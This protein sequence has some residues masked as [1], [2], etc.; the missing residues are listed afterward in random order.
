[1]TSSAGSTRSRPSTRREDQDRRRRVH[2]RGGCSA[3]TRRPRRSGA[4]SG[5]RSCRR[6]C[7]AQAQRPR[8][9]GPGRACQRRRRRRGHRPPSDRVRPVGR[10]GE[11]RRSDGVVGR[12]RADPL[13]AS[14]RELLGS[15]GF[16]ERQVDIKAWERRGPTS[17]PIRTDAPLGTNRA[18]GMP[19]QRRVVDRFAGVCDAGNGVNPPTRAAVA[20]ASHRWVRA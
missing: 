5:G 18:V 8:P 20:S 11:H 17:L 14:T 4:R 3:A 12:P 1:M 9:P 6:G 19:R 2:G 13:A 15:V 10:R 7:V 16:E